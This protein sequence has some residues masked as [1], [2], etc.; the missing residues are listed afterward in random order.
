MS[1]RGVPLCWREREEEEVAWGGPSR[2][3]NWQSR[4]QACLPAP[5][6]LQPAPGTPVPPALAAPHPTAISCCG[7]HLEEGQQV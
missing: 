2:V 7:C 5:Q 6:P 1:S 4:G 3:L